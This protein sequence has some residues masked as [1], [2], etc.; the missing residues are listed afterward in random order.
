VQGH[1]TG[2]GTDDHLE[3]KGKNEKTELTTIF[4]S[5]KVLVVQLKSSGGSQ[6]FS[7]LQWRTAFPE[8]S[9]VLMTDNILNCA[10]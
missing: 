10:A 3:N 9:K 7:M 6:P 5:T 4:R 1:Q 2:V 8:G